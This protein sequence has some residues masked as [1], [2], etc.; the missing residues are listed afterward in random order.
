MKLALEKLREM[1]LPYGE[2]CM[3]LASTVFDIGDLKA[4]NRQ[5]CLP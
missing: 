4:E 5:F 1:G 3:I 2:N